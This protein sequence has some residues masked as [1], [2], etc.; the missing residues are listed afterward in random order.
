ME[1]LTSSLSIPSQATNCVSWFY[2]FLFFLV[3]DLR[4]LLSK[5]CPSYSINYGLCCT[6]A[7][8]L[9]LP[10]KVCVYWQWEILFSICQTCTWRKDLSCEG[11]MKAPAFGFH[12]YVL[13]MKLTG[14]EFGGH[15]CIL[16]SKLYGCSTP[17]DPKDLNR[18][19]RNAL[20]LWSSTEHFSHGVSYSGNGKGNRWTNG[21][22]CIS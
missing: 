20:S 3:W 6:R 22:I 21:N 4:I 1:E 10:G 13:G 18:L 2:V 16:R 11:Q 12:V 8:C 15:T 14:N 5:Y 19:F 17:A 9:I 7:T